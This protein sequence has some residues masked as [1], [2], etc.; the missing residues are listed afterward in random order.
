MISKQETHWGDNA[1]SI[2]TGRLAGQA[3]GAVL[4]RYGDTVVLATAVRSDQPSP[5][6][7]FPLTV[8]YEER[9]YAAGKIPGGFIRREGRPSENATLSARLTDRPLRPLFPKGYKHEV[10]VVITVM[11]TDQQHEPDLL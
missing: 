3:D 8:Q 5:L 4:V 11:S 7:F 6:D 1:L 9:M 10:Q 2:E